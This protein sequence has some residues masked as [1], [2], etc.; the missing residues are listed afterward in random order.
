MAIII[1]TQWGAVARGFGTEGAAVR[2]PV[3]PEY[4]IQPRCIH[5]TLA[6]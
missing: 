4:A 5:E 1:Q 2:Q 6:P 3:R